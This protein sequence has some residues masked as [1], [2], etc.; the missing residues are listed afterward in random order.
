MKELY[1]EEQF[2]EETGFL[3][4]WVEVGSVEIRPGNSRVVTVEAEVENC[5]VTVHEKDNTVFVESHVAKENQGGWLERI[6][7]GNMQTKANLIIH[8]PPTCEIKAKTITGK[9]DIR[10]INAPI[11][12]KVTT[13]KASLVDIGGPIYAKLVT[14]KLNYEGIL[15]NGNHRFETTTG[16]IHLC[17]AKEPNAQLNAATTTGSLHC[18]FPLSNEQRN[19]RYSGGKIRGTLGSGEGKLKVKTTTGSLNVMHA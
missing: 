1:F 8:V 2:S 16:S 7:N 15:V 9:L 10:E 11:S 14:G 4:V 18:D 19:M 6:A 5:I 13:G 12:A 3:D 17:L